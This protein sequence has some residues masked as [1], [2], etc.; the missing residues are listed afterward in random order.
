[1]TRHKDSPAF[2]KYLE[3]TIADL[4]PPLEEME[5]EIEE[6]D[7]PN[8][9]DSIRIELFSLS[10]TFANANKRITESEAAFIMDI[11]HFINDNAGVF[12]NLSNKV[13]QNQIYETV[14]EYSIYN[15]MRISS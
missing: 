4:V 15:Y 2:I 11:Q 13:F 14:T 10:M 8:G 1:M 7:E 12:K 5:R 6:T 9:R 3:T